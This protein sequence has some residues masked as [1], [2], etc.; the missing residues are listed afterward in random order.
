MEKTAMKAAVARA[1]GSLEVRDAER[2]APAEGEVLVR[3]HA[4]SLNAVDWY[5]AHGRPYVARPLMGLLKPKSTE[6][7]RDFAGVVEEVGEGVDALARGDEVYGCADGAFAEYVVASKAIAG[8][9]ATLSFD[10][11]A[12][13]PLAALTALQALRDHA[14]VEPGQLVLVNG[15]SGGVGTFAIQIAKALGATVH[16]VCST[17]NVDQARRL[18]AD[19]AFDYTRED[20]TRAGARYDVVFDNAGNRS[21]LS[22]RRVLAPNATVVLVGGQRKRLLGPLGHVLRITL[23]SKLG[24]RTAVF[25]IARPN[26]DD[27]AILRDMIEAGQVA[28]AI[29]Q[30]FEL[31]QIAE[32]MRAMDGHAPAKIVLAVQTTPR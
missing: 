14:Q 29:G 1:Y 6:S 32:A 4:A 9:P 5:E 10:E 30:R 7:G 21:W 23:A 2:P 19:R 17:R 24:G 15:A 31:G 25:F 26:G 16:A 27:L 20:F 12:A 22:M 18:G 3:V 11:A 28:P 13:V 8:K